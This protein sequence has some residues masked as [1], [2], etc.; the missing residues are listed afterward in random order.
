MQGRIHQ[1]RFHTN[2]L[3][4]SFRSAARQYGSVR[5]RNPLS[6]NRSRN[7]HRYCNSCVLVRLAPHDQ[8]DCRS[9]EQH[10]KRNFVSSINFNSGQLV[11]YACLK[12]QPRTAPRVR[13][14]DQNSRITRNSQG[15]LTGFIRAQV[16]LR[17]IP[18]NGRRGQEKVSPAR[19]V[20]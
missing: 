4:L 18:Q 8:D 12:S 13:I 7:G 5:Q 14:A 16:S 11:P 10:R 19:T 2:L 17:E 15:T 9:I 3:I 1:L 20:F 6:R